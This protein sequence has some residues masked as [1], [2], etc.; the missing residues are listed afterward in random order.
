MYA[1]INAATNNIPTAYDTTAGSLIISS[2]PS[3]GQLSVQNTCTEIIIFTVTNAPNVT[4]ADSTT[5]NPAQYACPAAPSGGGSSF[6]QDKLKVSRGDR[7]FIKSAGSA[8]TSGKVTVV[9]W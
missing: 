5:T 9:I 7:I 4:P 6:T 2:C 3:S 8:L 1:I